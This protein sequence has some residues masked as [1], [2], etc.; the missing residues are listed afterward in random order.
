MAVVDLFTGGVLN[1]DSVSVS[2]SEVESNNA[3][4]RSSVGVLPGSR[5]ADLHTLEVEAEETG[6]SDTRARDSKP[7]TESDFEAKTESAAKNESAAKTESEATSVTEAGSGLEE[8]SEAESES[9]SMIT[10]GL[11]FDMSQNSNHTIVRSGTEKD[12]SFCHNPPA[13]RLVHKKRFTP[14]LVVKC[15]SCLH[16]SD[17]IVFDQ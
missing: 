2:V 5:T 10:M 8:I 4:R 11:I 16:L 12:I 3:A 1:I 14:D 6:W 15:T 9:E 7:E 13:N 17:W